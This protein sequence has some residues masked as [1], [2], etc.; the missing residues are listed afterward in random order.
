MRRPDYRSLLFGRAMVMLR[1]SGCKQQR[2]AICIML[3]PKCA[4]NVLHRTPVVM[5]RRPECNTV[6]TLGDLLTRVR[7][8]GLQTI[9]LLCTRGA[10]ADLTTL[11]W[12]L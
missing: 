8:D 11:L 12:L 6:T 1:A 5:T 10:G 4:C 9:G 3:I 7:C 2:K